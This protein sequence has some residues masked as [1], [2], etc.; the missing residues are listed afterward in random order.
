MQDEKCGGCG[1]NMLLV[2]KEVSVPVLEVKRQNSLDG[3]T[4]AEA[5]VFY[6]TTDPVWICERCHKEVRFLVEG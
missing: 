2:Q 3:N 1:G 5:K 6:K 4:W